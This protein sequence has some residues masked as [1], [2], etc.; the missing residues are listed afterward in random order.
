MIFNI[1]NIKHM[2]PTL[3]ASFDRKLRIR[4]NSFP[5]GSQIEGMILLITTELPLGYPS[6]DI[7]KQEN[8]PTTKKEKEKAF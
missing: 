5:L 2:N 1:F 4:L 6:G 3:L 8:L 7:A